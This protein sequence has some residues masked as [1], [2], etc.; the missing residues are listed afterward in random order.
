MYDYVKYVM[1]HIM[2]ISYMFK[3]CPSKWMDIVYAFQL[4]MYICKL[5][6]YYL[7]Y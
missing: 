3:M 5:F 4:Y 1:Y 6:C 7:Y 2:F